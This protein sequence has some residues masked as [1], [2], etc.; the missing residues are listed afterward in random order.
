MASNSGD[1]KEWRPITLAP[2]VENS[3]GSSNYAEF[4]SKAKRKLDAAGY[5]KYVAGD[6]YKPPVIPKLVESQTHTGFDE[7]GNEVT[8]TTRGNEVEVNIAKKGAESW[9]AQDK[10]ALAIIVE[11]VPGPKLYVV[12]D[13]KSAHE[14][15]EALK[16]TYEPTNALMAITLKSQI[17]SFM[18]GANPVAWRVE[19]MEKYQR[20]RRADAGMLP[21]HEFAKC[22]IT[23]M[24]QSDK[25]QYCRDILL[26][27]M[28]KSEQGGEPLKS[29]F[30]LA[31]LQREEYAKGLFTAAT[32]SSSSKT[33]L[34]TNDDGD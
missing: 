34:R 22:L 4:Q 17:T 23:N 26:E 33:R 16:E 32:S 25:W 8:V 2:I 28:S 14:A 3:D 29:A 18:C 7:D 9:L 11:A 1:G 30:V 10:K 27:E 15:W 31:R 5:W 21:D 6:E 12:E 24:S 13:C 19:I 20:L